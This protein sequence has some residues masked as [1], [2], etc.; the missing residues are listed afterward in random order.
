MA[1]NDYLQAIGVGVN[2]SSQNKPFAEWIASKLP[3]AA[4]GMFA[5]WAYQKIVS[6]FFTKQAQKYGADIVGSIGLAFIAYALDHSL[7]GWR[8]GF[9]DDM[10]QSFTDGMMGRGAPAVLN[11]VQSLFGSLSG[12][13]SNQ[14]AQGMPSASLDNAPEALAD[15][16]SLLK[17]SPETRNRLTSDLIAAM[18]RQD[19]RVDD[20]AKRNLAN[21]LNDLAGQYQR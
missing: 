5:H 6:E 9:S 14:K 2:Q 21:C 8:K 3:A 18:E 16:L 19:I 1:K 7:F 17:N 10:T 11:S 20:A 12:G 4:G 13:A 15:M